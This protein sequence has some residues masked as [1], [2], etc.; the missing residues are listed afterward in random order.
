M[1]SPSTSHLFPLLLTF[2]FSKFC[3]VRQYLPRGNVFLN[4]SDM[5]RGKFTACVLRNALPYT[6]AHVQV[7]FSLQHLGKITK[8]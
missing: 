4:W 8:N 6:T 3:Y 1:F 2:L 5:S 7:L